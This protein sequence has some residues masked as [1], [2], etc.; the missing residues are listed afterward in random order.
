MGVNKIKIWSIKSIFFFFFLS[1]ILVGL[2]N[3]MSI[4]IFNRK[5]TAA[6]HFAKYTYY[7]CFLHCRIGCE[8]WRQR[9]SKIPLSNR[10]WQRELP[11]V[12]PTQDICCRGHSDVHQCLWLGDV[13]GTT[14]FKYTDKRIF[15]L[16][17]LVLAQKAYFECMICNYKSEIQRKFSHPDNNRMIT[18]NVTPPIDK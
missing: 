11:S 13:R 16:F 3:L 10:R 18:G 14:F 6:A 2:F 4:I 9:L 15:K 1:E 12:F 17:C 7:L 8:I 5:W